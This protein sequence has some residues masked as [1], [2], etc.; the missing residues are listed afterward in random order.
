MN[1]GFDVLLQRLVWN[2]YSGLRFESLRLEQIL[3]LWQRNHLYYAPFWSSQYMSP[4]TDG[5]GKGDFLR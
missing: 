2:L 5:H 1:E 4:C 3:T